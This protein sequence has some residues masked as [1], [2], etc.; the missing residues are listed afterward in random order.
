[1]TVN[2]SADKILANTGETITFTDLTDYSP[3]A[4]GWNFGDGNSSSNQN[5][6]HSY[7]TP[8]FY[9]VTLVAGKSGLGGMMTKTNY[10]EVI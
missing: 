1:M 5:P 8:G 4:W 6:T 7:S 3:T 2:F 9:T 10:I